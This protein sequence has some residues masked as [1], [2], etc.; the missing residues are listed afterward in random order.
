MYAWFLSLES[1]TNWIVIQ[2]AMA[3][4]VTAKNEKNVIM[5]IN[6]WKPFTVNIISSTDN[7]FV[8]CPI[9]FFLFRYFTICV[10]VCVCVIF[11]P[12]DCICMDYKLSPWLSLIRIPIFNLFVLLF[13]QLTDCFYYFFFFFLLLFR[14]CIVCLFTFYTV[15]VWHFLFIKL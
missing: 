14:C 12:K 10:C 6:D 7:S 8:I 11:I 15:A 9:I 2:C 3:T 4:S 13:V 1:G 5:Y